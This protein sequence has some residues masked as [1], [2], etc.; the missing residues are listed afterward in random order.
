VST[1]RRTIW[2]VEWGEYSDYSVLCAFEDRADAEEMAVALGDGY[3]EM[4]LFSPGERPVKKSC[5]WR[6]TASIFPGGNTDLPRLFP[7]EAWDFDQVDPVDPE[8]LSDRPEVHELG[9]R[10]GHWQVNV[11]GRNRESVL[12]ACQDR[13]SKA[14][15]ERA[16]L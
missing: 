16:G 3:R 13:Y 2:V 12:K 1:G 8:Q 4:V 11:T 9:H 10:N 5:G 14:L 7:V 6:A 15:A